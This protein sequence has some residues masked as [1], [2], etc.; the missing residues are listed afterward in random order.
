MIGLVGE[1][2][3]E[4]SDIEM[5]KMNRHFEERIVEYEKRIHELEQIVDRV[6]SREM[7]IK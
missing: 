5:K 1:H 6:M 7:N 2:L 3:A 4:P